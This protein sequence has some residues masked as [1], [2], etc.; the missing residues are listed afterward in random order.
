M[1]RT[2]LVVS[3]SFV[4][5][6]ALGCTGNATCKDAFTHLYGNKCTLTVNGSAVTLTDAINGCETALA[7]AKTKNC[8]GTYHTALNCMN[9]STSCTECNSQLTAYS[10]CMK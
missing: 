6:V 2:R 3:L 4:S 9:A 7:Q 10:T 8:E 1:L 5:F